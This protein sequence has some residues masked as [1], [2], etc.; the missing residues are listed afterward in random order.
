MFAW[1]HAY[2]DRAPAFVA[3]VVPVLTTYQLD[4]PER[5]LHPV[6][7]RLLD[8]FG[9]R[10]GVLETIARNIHTFGWSGPLT[11]YFALYEGPLD[12]LRDHPKPKVRRAGSR[13]RFADSP[14]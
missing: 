1:C 8:E 7:T 11:N 2:P 6:M 5:P 14:P 12:T 4:I 3:G 10:E 9:D 13:R